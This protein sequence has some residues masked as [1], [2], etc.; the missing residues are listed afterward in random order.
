MET[1]WHLFD[2]HNH[3]KEIKDMFGVLSFSN[4]SVSAV[5]LINDLKFLS[6]QKRQI[7]M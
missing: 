3:A 7:F 6:G 5:H 4:E 2:F 1:C